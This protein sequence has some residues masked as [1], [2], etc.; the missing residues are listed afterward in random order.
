MHLVHHHVLQ[1]LVVHRP[2]EYERLQGLSCAAAG[3]HVLPAVAEAILDLHLATHKDRDPQTVVQVLLALQSFI[4]PQDT[5]HR[6][7]PGLL[8]APAVL[9]LLTAEVQAILACSDKDTRLPIQV[10]L[11]IFSFR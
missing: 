4:P 1:L 3:Q 10:V 2:H 5:Q 8:G 7:I 6:C 11:T 9:H